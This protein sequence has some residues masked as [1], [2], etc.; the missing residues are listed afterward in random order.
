MASLA[1]AARHL[2]HTIVKLAAVRILV[3]HR[4]GAVLEP[5]DRRLPKLRES[6]RFRDFSLRRRLMAISARGSDVPA[7]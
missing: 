1:A 4:A 3:A 7:G 6:R 5:I 2:L